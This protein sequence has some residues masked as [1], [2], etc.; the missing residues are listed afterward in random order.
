MKHEALE[1]NGFVAEKGPL[2]SS[3]Q[4]P[5]VDSSRIAIFI[6]ASVVLIVYA[7]CY[8]LNVLLCAH[9][10]LAKA[11]MDGDYSSMSEP[12]LKDYDQSIG[13]IPSFAAAAELNR[14]PNDLNNYRHRIDANVE[15]QRKYREVLEGLQDKVL[16]Y[17]QKAAEPDACVGTSFSDRHSATL[18]SYQSSNQ[19]ASPD[20]HAGSGAGLLHVITDTNGCMPSTSL[21]CGHLSVLSSLEQ[22]MSSEFLLAQIRAEQSRSATLEDI[23]EMLRTQSNAAVEANFFLQDDLI[24]LQEALKLAQQEVNFERENVMKKYRLKA[25]YQCKNLL[26][27]W[28]VCNRLKK[29]MKEL[30]MEAETDLDRQKSEFVRSVNS[31]ERIF[32]E[33]QIRQKMSSTKSTSE[34]QETIE[35]V[36]K[37]YDEIVLRNVQLEHEKSE[38]E[39]RLLNS[40]S[41]QKRSEEERDQ[42]LASIRRIQQIPELSDATGRRARSV[43]PAGITTSHESTV[44]QVRRALRENLEEIKSWKKLNDETEDRVKELEGH[45][46]SSERNRKELE[47]ACQEQARATEDLKREC[48]ER[49]RSVRRL[50]DRAQRL[51]Q[52]KT[53]LQS[54]VQVQMDQINELKSFHQKTIDDLTQ[55]HR[56]EW[57]K[58]RQLM[59]GELEEKQ[60]T[61]EGRFERLRKEI[62][63]LK[64]DLGK[65]RHSENDLKVELI[66]ERRKIENYE[67]EAVEASR[68]L[69]L[70]R[71]EQ[72]R[73]QKNLED[74]EIFIVDL[75]KQLD[76]VR[77]LLQVAEDAKEELQSEKT[78]LVKENATYVEEITEL[79]TELMQSGMQL[80]NQQTQ[81]EEQRNNIKTYK[82]QIMKHETV[83]EQYRSTISDL[84]HRLE[85]A[86][87]ESE[88]LKT[89]ISSGQAE[90]EKLLGSIKEHS[91]ERLNAE[92]EREDL[93]EEMVSAK[94]AAEEYRSE[95]ESLVNR[96]KEMDEQIVSC[97]EEIEKWKVSD[98]ELSQRLREANAEL[99]VLQDQ[100]RKKEVRE[101]KEANQLECS[102]EKIEHLKAE[103]VQLE[104]AYTD[105]VNQ[106][107]AANNNLT[108]R[109]S[110][111]TLN[112][113]DVNEKHERLTNSHKRLDSEHTQ[114]KAELEDEISR[115]RRELT[116]NVDD[117][118]MEQQEW[119]EHRAQLEDTKSLFEK[120]LVESVE[121]AQKELEEAAEREERLATNLSNLQKEQDQSIAKIQ[122]LEHQL[123]HANESVNL[124]RTNADNALDSLRREKQ[125]IEIESK[126]LRIKYERA[127]RKVDDLESRMVTVSSQLEKREK[128]LKSAETELIKVEDELRT[129][130]KQEEEL[131]FKLSNITRELADLHEQK[132]NLKEAFDKV[133]NENH[134]LSRTFVDMRTEIS[135]LQSK[136]AAAEETKEK[137]VAEVER[138]KGQ[139]KDFE[140]LVEDKKGEI[141]SLSALLKRYE[142]NQQDMLKELEELKEK[143]SRLQQE[144]QSATQ[145]KDVLTRELGSVQK[146][147]D[148]KTETNQKAVND[149]LEN[150]RQVERE[151]VEV[152]RLVDEKD[153]ELDMLR[154]RLDAAENRRRSAEAK[155]EQHSE[156]IKKLTER[157][158]HYEN[159]A[160]KALS[161]AKAHSM[162]RHKGQTG[163]S[164]Q[165]LSKSTLKHSNLTLDESYL[166]DT[167]ILR[168]SSSF[169]DVSTVYQDRLV[170]ENS[171][172]IG[173]DPEKLNIRSSVE[174]TFKIL[175][176]R[177]DEL[178]R[179]KNATSTEL[180]KMKAECD[181]HQSTFATMENRIRSLEKQVQSLEHER[182]TLEAKLASSR[183]LLLSQEESLRAN[184]NDRRLFKAKMVS[185]DLH[186]R[187]KDARLQVLGEQI[188]VL[189]NDI[190]RLEKEKHQFKQLEGSWEVERSRLDHQL[191]SYASQIDQLKS[192]ITKLSRQKEIRFVSTADSYSTK[193]PRGPHQL[194]I[195]NYVKQISLTEKLHESER[196]ISVQKDRCM[197]LERTITTH[198]ESLIRMQTNE[199]HYKTKL[200]GMKRSAHEVGQMEKRLETMRMEM[201]AL[202][203]RCKTSE[204]EREQLR[205]EFLE[206]KSKYNFSQQKINDLQQI[207][208]EVSSDKKRAIDRLEHLERNE[209]DNISLKNDLRRELEGLRSERLTLS[210]ELE[211]AKRKIQKLSVEKRE[212]EAQ[213]S[214][215]DRERA[216]LKT[217]IQ[218]LELD[219][220]RIEST[221][222]QTTAERQA[223]DKSLGAMEKENS[224]LYRNC[225]LLQSQVANLERESLNKVAETHTKKKVQLEGELSRV[226]QEKRQL[227]K[228][229]EQRE[230][231]YTHKSRVFEAQIANLREQLEVER[232][233]LREQIVERTKASTQ[234]LPTEARREIT[235]RRT[236]SRMITSS[237]TQKTPFRT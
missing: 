136:V 81:D 144:A 42:A 135:V 237:P 36:M 82:E 119:E 126:E 1:R 22:N 143:N 80:E 167:H 39:R 201:D 180:L 123:E 206:V 191:G 158:S 156:T 162:R 236:H 17:R 90:I 47:K 55:L 52:E 128:G 34:I 51:E 149:L 45:L 165:D 70:A 208:N 84:E 235:V 211:D 160:K 159:S 219:K 96:I 100:F 66:A 213:R 215:L 57:E 10:L 221:I 132:K 89:D 140:Y 223:L 67:R 114:T 139:V 63:V 226:N 75:D 91:R 107:T 44:R 97:H 21:S 110:E 217:H 30:K 76:E 9:L 26:D 2:Q 181:G 179:E 108:H 234:S 23:I 127:K 190:A 232:R 187:D 210:A 28:M 38:V 4:E 145:E 166:G 64:V 50:T 33:N 122:D 196:N 6:C 24:R 205:R 209:R 86:N 198:K 233:R 54:T 137:K 87:N 112:L 106:L 111:L 229:L 231:N 8:V 200:D 79:R 20:H 188:Q 35:E 27:L 94:R 25:E 147:L 120:R 118:K 60:K 183:Q 37:K 103:I 92:K 224:E 88:T 141:G 164:F 134:D 62:D 29:Q 131:E 203:A 228:V 202:G 218:A 186:S 58:H 152:I 175:K 3:P 153:S 113:S 220:Q 15:E 216:A 40:E 105:K 61:N 214:R 184:D 125:K 85:I 142:K 41:V 225:S 13:E 129:K 32:K 124:D 163:A 73:L 99:E 7:E 212:I 116:A 171:D 130:T 19:F 49:A 115:I 174:I 5:S 16:K 43:S 197:E 161:Y 59:D 12:S 178:E 204:H 18:S 189:R 69:Q 109:I 102:Q 194:A 48:D 155:I 173:A 46:Q 199:D 182:T 78:V 177:I 185:A 154:G 193:C 117:H 230:H 195:Q 77:S 74:K 93:Y 98:N 65:S 151:K 53:G 104:E 170:P 95:N 157:L 168:P 101:Q 68:R 83:V 169:V 176:D 71:E 121:R 192:D 72:E 133:E 138:I 148:R 172:L 14:V 150:Y 31:L 207:I 56:S 222:R 227:E 11:I 146:T